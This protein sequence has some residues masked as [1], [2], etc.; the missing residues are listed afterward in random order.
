MT[1]S[2]ALPVQESVLENIKICS[3]EKWR[4]A[5]IFDPMRTLLIAL[6]MTFST[7]AGL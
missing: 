4:W 1:E 5:E 3:T 2:F 7:Q 6:L